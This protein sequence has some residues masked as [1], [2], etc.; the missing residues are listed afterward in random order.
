MKGKYVN[1]QIMLAAL[2]GKKRNKNKIAA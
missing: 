2:S 1:T